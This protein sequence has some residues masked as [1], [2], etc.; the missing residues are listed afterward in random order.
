MSKEM[1]FYDSKTESPITRSADLAHLD[2]HSRGNK[3]NSPN[4]GIL[5]RQAQLHIPLV[6][7]PVV[8]PGRRRY[9]TDQDDLLAFR[10]QPLQLHL[11]PIQLFRARVGNIGMRW[12]GRT[13]VHCLVGV[14][15]EER[16]ERDYGETGG[17][18]GSH[19]VGPSDE[20]V[21]VVFGD[22]GGPDAVCDYLAKPRARC[23]LV[24]RERRLGGLL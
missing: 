4:D 2:V 8:V 9:M 13:T 18:D 11:Q 22:K 1:T 10:P 15:E 17:D 19:I 16:V 23:E 12:R 5:K 3:Q 20:S 7:D 21:I 24:R 14:V 6:T